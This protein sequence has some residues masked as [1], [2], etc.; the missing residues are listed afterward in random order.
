MTSFNHYAI[1][2]VAAFLH[3]VVGGLAPAAPGWKRA[4]VHPRPGGTVT[5]ATTTFE[6]R[7]GPYR[8]E[9]K[10]H[11]N[12]THKTRKMMVEVN[13]PPNGEAQVILPGVDEVVGSGK[14]DWEVDWATDKRW[15]PV[16]TPGPQSSR[17]PDEFVS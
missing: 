5:S 7:Y 9:W 6:S 1:G 13:V 16:G 8:V 4:L 10:L 15:P 11:G 12:G 3:A 14:W 17:I 2:S